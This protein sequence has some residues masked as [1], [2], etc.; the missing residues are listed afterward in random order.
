MPQANACTRPCPAPAPRPCPSARS[1]GCSGACSAPKVEEKKVGRRKKKELPK[2][3]VVAPLR[4]SHWALA[5]CWWQ[6]ASWPPGSQVRA[7]N[8]AVENHFERTLRGPLS[9]ADE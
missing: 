5:L 7:P 8:N 1:E 6:A 3:G 4:C 9:F 2:T